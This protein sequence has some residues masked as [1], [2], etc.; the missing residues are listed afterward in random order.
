LIKIH[1]GGHVTARKLVQVLGTNLRRWIEYLAAILI[2]NGIYFLSLSAHL[3]GD[4]RHR[5][6]RIDRGMVLDFA[7]CVA[8]YGLIRLGERVSR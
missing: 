2:G 5:T 1:E 7:I 8:V 4:L 3:P 6:Y